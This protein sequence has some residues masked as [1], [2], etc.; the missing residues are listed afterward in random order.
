[1]MHPRTIIRDHIAR[2]LIRNG[3]W[4]DAVFVSRF[5]AIDEECHFP[6]VCIYTPA[7]RTITEADTQ[8]LNE[9]RQE[10]TLQI[11]VRVKRKPDMSQVWRHSAGMPNA[12]NQSQPADHELDQACLAIE[13][14]IFDMFDSR[15]VTDGDQCLRVD[16]VS[17]ISTQ[18]AG[19]E[20]GNVPF[21]LAIVEFKLEY[22][23]GFLRNAPELCDLSKIMGN[24]VYNQCKDNGSLGSINNFQS[25]QEVCS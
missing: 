14:L 22:T 16:V 6:N 25:T 3:A 21:M 5:T 13:N 24:I 7:E 8:R 19:D 2:E 10:L 18:I 12:A 9:R 11:E 20:A 23:R 15:N 1:M 17:E 4:G